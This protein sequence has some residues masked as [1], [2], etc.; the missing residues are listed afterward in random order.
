MTGCLPFLF[1][2]ATIICRF[3]GLP[4][5]VDACY[6]GFIL[7]WIEKIGY[8]VPTFDFRVEGVTS[9]TADCHKCVV[10]TIGR[11]FSPTMTI[12]LPVLLSLFC[13]AK[14]IGIGASHCS[15][16]ATRQRVPHAFSTATR[17]SAATCT[18]PT[19]SGLEVCMCRQAWP[20]RARAPTLRWH[21]YV[22]GV[23]LPLR[24]ERGWTRGVSRPIFGLDWNACVRLVLVF[25]PHTFRP[26]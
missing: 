21:G 3:L 18:T 6:G 17:P 20:A 10:L 11:V 9:I 12:P 26:R 14:L 25:F 1:F 23:V 8:K 7:P 5:H 19:L 2:P 24:V 15:G 22:R 13:C 16:M 4:L